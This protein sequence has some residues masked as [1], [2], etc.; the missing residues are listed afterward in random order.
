MSLIIG[1]TGGIGSGKSTVSVFFKALGIEVVDADVVARLVVENGQPALQKISHYFG[2]DIIEN[3]ALNRVKLR[4][5]IFNDPIKKEWLN[6]LLHP[7]IRDK[8]L[9][10]LKE[11][12]SDYVLL[13]APLLFE[14]NLERYCD[15]VIV[16]DLDMQLQIIRATARDD[17]SPETIKAIIASQISRSQRV[18]KADFI[19][20]NGDVSLQH[21]E[22]SVIALDKQLRTLQ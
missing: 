1:L 3:G 5:I 7:L 13:E 15:Y 17:S 18:E 9:A 8:M 14:N 4:H 21:L 2:S 12:K 11:A 22:I 16:V 10:Q 6:A 19:I 20:D